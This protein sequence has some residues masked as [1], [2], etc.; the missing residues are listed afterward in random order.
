MP[1]ITVLPNSSSVAT[2]GW[3]Y[4]ADDGYDPSK[5]SIRPSGPRQRTLRYP[6]INGEAKTVAEKNI[7]TKHLADLGRENHRDV[8]ISITLQPKAND[9]RGMYE[10]SRWHIPMALT[11]LYRR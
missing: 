8:H 6:A 3:A 9:A 11:Y 7:V 1:V 4:V 2:P 10:R 5:E